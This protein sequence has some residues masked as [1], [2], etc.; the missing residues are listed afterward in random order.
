[1]F[2]IKQCGYKEPA[3]HE[4]Y[5]DSLPAAAEVAKHLEVEKH[6][7]NYRKCPHAVECRT[8]PELLGTRVCANG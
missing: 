7:G 2:F 8:I 5:V 4:K 1:M 3:Q 6:N